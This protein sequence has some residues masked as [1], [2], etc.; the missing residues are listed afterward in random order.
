MQEN[1]I[2]E[3]DCIMPPSPELEKRS[4]EVP[5]EGR[6]SLP[7]EPE[8]DQ[9]DQR[10]LT[11]I[12]SRPA[13]TRPDTFVNA[14]AEPAPVTG[15]GGRSCCSWTSPTRRRPRPRRISTTCCSRSAR[16]RPAAC[17]TSTASVLHQARRD[18]VGQRLR[19]SDRGLVS[20]ATA[21]VLLHERNYGFGTHPNNAQKLVEDAIA[22]ADPNVNF[23]D[24][25][26]DGDGVVDALVVIC[27]GSGGEQTGNV[28][29]IWSTSGTSRPGPRR[30]HHQPL[31]HGS[32][33]RPC[34]GD[35][36]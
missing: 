17:A 33:R 19:R 30:R 10:S 20:G 14:R 7:G 21:E 22:L 25:D 5:H 1:C 4:S 31:L 3:V 29:D 16:T 9:L 27:A 24:Y 23:A 18:R 12:L 36:P 8:R 26:N 32:R 34:R 2:H 13:R 15:R 28:N 35:G 6:R 11:L